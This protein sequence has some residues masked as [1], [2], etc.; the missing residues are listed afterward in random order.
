MAQIFIGD[1]VDTVNQKVEFLQ[2]PYF[3]VSNVI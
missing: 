1:K 3:F 2:L